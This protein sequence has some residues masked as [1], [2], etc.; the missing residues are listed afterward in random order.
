MNANV[1]TS[2][3]RC[4]WIYL[5]FSR[6]VKSLKYILK[7]ELL[8]KNLQNYTARL[9][10]HDCSGK[11]ISQSQSSVSALLLVRISIL[12]RPLDSSEFCLRSPSKRAKWYLLMLL[13]TLNEIC[14]QHL[15]HNRPSIN[16]ELH[17]SLLSPLSPLKIF[18][19]Q[20]GL[21]IKSNPPS[22]ACLP[23][24]CTLFW[25]CLAHCRSLESR[26]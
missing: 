17:S 2:G 6:D 4:T 3:Y 15:A 11:R 26:D 16:N 22:L 19:D 18:S 9:E 13:S 1:W 8:K 24:M 25:R 5:S 20:N 23:I 21:L 12:T 14:V 7:M 10:N